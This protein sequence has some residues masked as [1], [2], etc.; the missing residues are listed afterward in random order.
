[1][2]WQGFE[3]VK[4][5]DRNEKALNALASSQMGLREAGRVVR[6]ADALEPNHNYIERNEHYDG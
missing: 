3:E 4:T 1:L 6:G 5:A 2:S